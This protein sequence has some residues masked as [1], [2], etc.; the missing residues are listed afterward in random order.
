MKY[1]KEYLDEIKMRLKVSQVVGKSVKLKKRGKEFIGLSPFSNEKTPSFTVNDEKGFYH[2]FSSGEHGNIFDFL[3]K[4]KNYKFGE[5]VKTLSAEA[6]MQPFKF[7]KEDTEKQNRWKIYNSILEKYAAFCHD[8]LIS[9]KHPEILKYLENRKVTKKEITFFNLGYVPQVNDFYEKLKKEFDEKK[10]ILSGVYYFDENKKKYVDR[11]R[12]RLIFPVKNLNGSIFALGGR[13][14]SKSTF[15]KYINS[16]ETEFYKKGNNLYNIDSAKKFRDKSEEVFIVE[17]YMDAINLHKFGISNVVANL[18]TAMTEKQIDLIWRFFKNP[19][20]CLDGD[21]SGQ[22]A[23]LRAAERLFP[24]IKSDHNIYFLTLPE[25]I[26]PDSYI[27]K[28]GKDSFLKLAENKQEIQ[29][30]VWDMYLSEVNYNDPRSLSIFE[31][32]IKSLCNDIKDKTLAKYYLNNYM[33]KINDLTP[34]INFS[35]NKFLSKVTVL[36]PLQKTK[37]IYRK[38]NKFSEKELKEFS[39]LFLVINNFYIFSKKVE[40]ISDIL[41]S[42]SLLNEFKQQIIE[43]ILSEKFSEKKQLNNKDFD[44][45][46]EKLVDLINLNA[47]IKI[48]SKNKKEKEILAIFDEIVHEIKKLD[49]RNKIETLES[50][51]SL[52]LDEKLY[53]ELLS[54][55][56]QLKSG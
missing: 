11:F 3:M 20:I 48:I 35:K 32:K 25:N 53:S 52:N 23:A 31:K 22:K 34:N 24:L 9:E 55:R 54:L 27:N 47:P 36:N 13:S 43:D 17:G 39:I 26:D 50:K 7:T 6:G 2:C 38:R 14:L 10:I 41:F 29:N 37:E 42:N 18:G 44:V 46:F 19:I 56:N 45:K 28:N 15:A 1:P 33:Q 30:F 4:I 51:V 16:P 12:G 8:E 5:A 40:L 49:L 21:V